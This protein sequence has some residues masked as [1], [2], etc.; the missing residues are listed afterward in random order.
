MTRQH[1][2]L[3]GQWQ[4]WADADATLKQTSLNAKTAHTVGVPAPWQAHDGLRDYSGIGWYQCAFN[5][6]KKM[7]GADRVMALHFG[8]VDY[9][10]DVWV[11]GKR[12]GT[13]EGGYLPFEFDI[14]RLVQRVRTQSW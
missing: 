5:V 4:F 6:S 9:I 8:A 12:V 3:D 14:T 1:L 11:N 2:S 7:L 10:A 13:H